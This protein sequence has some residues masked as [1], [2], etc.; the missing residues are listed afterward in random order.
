MIDTDSDNEHKNENISYEL[1]D[2]TKV[3][4]SITLGYQSHQIQ[5]L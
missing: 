3:T 2:Q 5:E 4:L 1:R